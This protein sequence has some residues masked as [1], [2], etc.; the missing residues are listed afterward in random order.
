MDLTSGLDVGLI[1]YD[2]GDR[3]ATDARNDSATTGTRLVTIVRVTGTSAEHA[4]RLARLGA[5][6][7]QFPMTTRPEDA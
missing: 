3:Y 5:M 7:N 2:M 6:G 4:K 1:D